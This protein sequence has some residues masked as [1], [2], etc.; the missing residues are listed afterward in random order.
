M[1]M[2]LRQDKEGCWVALCAAASKPQPGDVYLNDAQDRAIRLKL[3]ADWLSEGF[4]FDPRERRAEMPL[5]AQ[6]SN[7]HRGL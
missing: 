3:E 6:P 4:M 5:F 7:S 2:R 1:A